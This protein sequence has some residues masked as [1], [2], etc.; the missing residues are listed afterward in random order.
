MRSLLHLG[1]GELERENVP[2]GNAGGV[3]WG[4]RCRQPED[5]QL[6]LR[7]DIS[8][9]RDLDQ[10]ISDEAQDNLNTACQ[11]ARFCMVPQDKAPEVQ[12]EV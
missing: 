8:D 4:Q 11:R 12:L 2:E 5:M 1:G 9:W 3:G 6:I 10:G 7:V